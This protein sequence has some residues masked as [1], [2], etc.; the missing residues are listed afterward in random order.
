MSKELDW[1]SGSKRFSD[2]SVGA[3]VGRGTSIRLHAAH[4]S[5]RGGARN[6]CL[7]KCEYGQ[8]RASS[9]RAGAWIRAVEAACPAPHDGKNTQHLHDEAGRWSMPPSAHLSCRM[10]RSTQAS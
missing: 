3:N 2:K 5:A 8:V 7:W 10:P 4:E 9:G 1:R 6:A